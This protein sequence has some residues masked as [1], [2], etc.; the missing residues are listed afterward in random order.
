M[1]FKYVNNFTGEVF[2]SLPKAILTVFK[3]IKNFPACRTVK[4]LSISKIK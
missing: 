4:M 3:D 2:T 1:Q